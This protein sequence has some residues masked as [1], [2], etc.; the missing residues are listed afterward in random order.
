MEKID[1]INAFIKMFLITFFIYLTYEKIINYK[2]RTIKYIIILL[3]SGV[4]SIVYIILNRY[5][6]ALITLIILYIIYGIII[7]RIIKSEF[8]N[9]AYVYS[10]VIAYIIYLLAIIITAAILFILLPEREYTNPISSLIISCITCLLFLSIFKIKRIRKGLNFLKDKSTNKDIRNSAIFWIGVV[11]VIFGFSQK[12]NDMILKSCIFIGAIF[13]IIGIS[14]WIKTQITKFYKSKMRDRTIEIQKNEIDEQARIMEELKSENLKLATAIHKYNKKLSSL[15]FAMK[16][17]LESENKTEFANEL[18]VIL[19]ETKEASKNFAKETQINVNK[20]PLTN[21]TG[22]D[23]MFKYMQEEARKKNINFDVKL[24]TSINYLIEN[25]ISKDKFETLIGDHLKDAIIAIDA[26][27]A[28]YKSI[29]VTLGLV[30]GIYEFSI[31]DT[32]IEFEIETLLKLGEEQVTTHKNE[33]GSGIGFMTTFETLKECKASLIIEEYN[34]KTTNYTKSVT[35]KF[36]GRN[37]YKIISYRAE[38]IKEQKH[39]R[40]IIIEESK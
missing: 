19:E 20:L 34:P 33:G 14:I 16:N 7:N 12:M 39:K 1:L 5:L 26:S 36:D 2:N 17:V 8:N 22:I 31:Y 40:R 21:N 3:T 9:V 13:I 11:I 15:E 18:S 32:G 35:V 27:T 10:C 28:L 37:E 29:L 24:N 38:K 30:E 25:I 23:N 6:P 4:I